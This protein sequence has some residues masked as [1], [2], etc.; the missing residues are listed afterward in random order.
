MNGKLENFLGDSLGRTIVKLAVLSL[1]V[2]FAMAVFHFTPLD[3]WYSVRYFV[4]WI[5]HAGFE[6]F[7]DIMRYLVWGAMV[8]VP[9]FLLMRLLSAGRR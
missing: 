9:V 6:A 5:Y 4:E 1:I 8:V 2:G 7:G 3:L